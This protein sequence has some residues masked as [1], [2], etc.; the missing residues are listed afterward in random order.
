M[1]KS[2]ISMGGH[3]SEWIR[4]QTHCLSEFYLLHQARTA[5][6]KVAWVLW[7]LQQARGIKTSAKGWSVVAKVCS[8]LLLLPLCVWPWK[9]PPCSTRTLA[10]AA[11]QENL[12]KED[13]ILTR[14]NTEL[15]REVYLVHSYG[16]KCGFKPW[17]EPEL[18]LQTRC[19]VFLCANP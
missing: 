8:A 19:P 4:P 1:W 17:P 9:W 12:E 18:L 14:G 13:F 15:V 16:K 3:I 6:C 5:G 2:I 10:A 11:P 7:L